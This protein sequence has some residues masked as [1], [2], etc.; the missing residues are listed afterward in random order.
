[1][2]I[3][4]TKST[5]EAIDIVSGMLLD[6]LENKENQVLGLATGKTMEPVYKS[7]V[8]K[9]N[10]G[11]LNIEHH[12]FFML[13]EYIG[14]PEDHPSSFKSYINQHFRNPLHLQSN[15]FSLPSAGT[16]AIDDAG[17]EYEKKIKQAGGI[18]LQLLGIGSNGHIVFNEPGS[19][20]DSRTRVVRL[21]EETRQANKAQFASESV[22]E[23]ALSMGVASI[24][25]ARELLMLATGTSKADAIKYLFN[26][27]DDESCP[28]TFL[29]THQRFTLVL[30]PEAASKI[31]LNI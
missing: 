5:T 2:R 4:I 11:H 29:K 28:A 18:D 3:I 12:S 24:M 6:K 27:H 22:P 16:F 25:E 9:I 31:S 13:D 21:T 7:L 20:L 17:E 8:E 19:S 15:Q 10:L 23:E 1:M 14:I 26:H 30:D